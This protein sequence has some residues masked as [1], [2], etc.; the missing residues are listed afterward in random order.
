MGRGR[1]GRAHRR[2]GA[3][4]DLADGRR[5]GSR[6]LGTGRRAGRRRAP[7]PPCPRDPHP[8]RR[9][10]SDPRPRGGHPRHGVRRHDHAHRLRLRPP[11]ERHRRDPRA[12]GGPLGGAAPTSTTASTSRSAGRCRSPS[13]TEMREAIEAGFPSFKVFTTNVLPPHPKRP[14]FRLDFGRIELAMGKAARHGGLMVVHGEDEELVQSNY[15]RFRDEGRMDGTN[16]HLVHTKLS[17]QLA[18]RRTIALARATGA[19]I[20]FVHTSAREGVEAIEAARAA[21][22]ARLRRDAP[23]V[24]LLQRRVLQDARAASART[25]TRRSSS[26]RT[27]RRSGAGSCEGGVSTLATDE[28]PTSLALKLRGRTIE[29]V[30][31]GN[32]GAEARMGIAF[33]E[34][35]VKRGMS[36]ER[37]AAHHRDERRADLR[38]LPAERRHRAGQRRRP[39][40][41]R[42]GDPEDPHARRLPRERLQPVGGLGRVRL[43]GHHAPARQGDRGPRPGARRGRGRPARPPPDRSGGAPP[44]RLLTGRGRLRPV[45]PAD[46]RLSATAGSRPGG[47]AGRGRGFR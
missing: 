16:L 20:Y 44:P 6:R 33:T 8:P 25:R 37:F 3:A 39:R 15:E 13:S 21:G 27:R 26:R 47:G 35:V 14:S 22:A 45:S 11:G 23:P 17:E 38:A 18:F 4:R 34:G 29:D 5:P 43:A 36:L 30:T 41:D 28:Y 10:R 12:A 2:A 9:P 1:P 24:R 40:P 46:S 31:G 19:G 42:P 32:L 7:H